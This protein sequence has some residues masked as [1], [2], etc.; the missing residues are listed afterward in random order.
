MVGVESA[1]KPA[2]LDS[3]ACPV[4]GDRVSGYHY[5]LLTCESCKGFFKRTVQN[6]KSYQCSAESSCHV[7]KACR[8]RCPRC[9]FAKCIEKGM[10]IEA[11][12][13]D[14]MRGG[15]NKFGSYYKRDRAQRM[16]RIALKN[17]PAQS[18]TYYG[19]HPSSID[20]QVTSS[21][22]V[23]STNTQYFN[24]S[25][26][27]KREFDS[28]LQSPI[29]S[30]N[31]SPTNQ[32]FITHRPNPYLTD[33]ESLAVILGSSID[34]SFPVYPTV[35]PEPFEYTEHLVQQPLL[36]Y[37][38]FH[39]PVSYASMVPMG[40]VPLQRNNTNSG[41]N[42]NRSSPVLPVCP[43]PTKKTIDNVFYK[44][45][46][47][48][49]MHESLP[50]DSRIFSLL[51]KIDKLDPFT[52]C[53]SAVEENLNQ[54]VTWAKSAPYFNKL[55]MEDQMILLHTSWAMIHIIDI[56]FAVITGDIHTTVKISDGLEIPTGLVALMGE[57]VRLSKWNDLVNNLILQGFN[58]YDFS[59]FRF[60]ALFQEEG[61]L[62]VRNQDLV[63]STRQ[64][65]MEAWGEYRGVTNSVLLPQYEVFTQIKSLAHASQEFLFERSTVGEVGSSLLAEML[66][67]A[68]L[69]PAYMR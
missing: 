13:E 11:V 29:L 41:A 64:S 53:V 55:E 50:E 23:Q 58:R 34:Q 44:S 35:K 19:S 18:G 22:A 30:C 39:T 32:S 17:V 57:S 25:A 7:D 63:S 62:R 68:S 56:S 45:A 2:V 40:V 51:R 47:L 52:Y 27:I 8:K 10:K 33:S 4:C 28:I 14:R 49:I 12:R 38:A 46:V 65:L 48:T 31:N 67:S 37:S 60:L 1:L 42:S 21:T 3:E 16:Q 6:K 43:T 9:R 5:G 20:Q 15:R 66:G 54:L 69:I 59:A 36:E 24:N 61:E 26:K